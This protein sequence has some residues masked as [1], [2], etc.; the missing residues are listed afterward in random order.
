M[1][2]DDRGDWLGVIITNQMIADG[3]QWDGTVGAEF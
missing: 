1:G 3:A 2:R